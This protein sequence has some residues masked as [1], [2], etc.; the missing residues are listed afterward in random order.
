MGSN[1]DLRSAKTKICRL[2]TNLANS[3]KHTRDSI[4]IHRLI[5]ICLLLVRA[6]VTVVDI[7]SNSVA[8]SLN[9]IEKD[10]PRYDDDVVFDLEQMQT[11]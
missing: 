5:G 1:Y 4:N 10:R 11:E 7:E 3:S 2:E 9:T 8:R 6:C